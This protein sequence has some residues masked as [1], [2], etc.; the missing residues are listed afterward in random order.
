MTKRGIRELG[1][2]IA[3]AVYLALVLF[4]NI[5]SPFFALVLISLAA[6]ELIDSH[7]ARNKP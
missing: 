1:L 6:F 4:R 7:R 3:G 2:G 5:Y